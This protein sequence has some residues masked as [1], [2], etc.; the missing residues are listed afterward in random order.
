MA[1]STATPARSRR[2]PNRAPRRAFI[3]HA[4]AFALSCTIV[5]CRNDRPTPEEALRQFLQSLRSRR[6]KDAWGALSSGSRT[7][8]TELAKQTA[9]AR[10]EPVPKEHAAALFTELELVALREPE[11][12]SVVSPLGNEVMLRVSVKGG[13]TANIRMVLEESRWKVDLM[14]AL[15]PYDGAGI[16]TATTAPAAPPA[17]PPAPGSTSPDPEPAK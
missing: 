17:A 7:K 10:G 16:R 6:A 2:A 11:S 9:E 4:S 15:E 1:L 12:V 5:G 8:I 13:Q 14:D 3:A